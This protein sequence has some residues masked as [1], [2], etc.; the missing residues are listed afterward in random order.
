MFQ[1]FLYKVAIPEVAVALIR[2][3]RGGDYVAAM[4]TLQWSY[5]YGLRTFPDTDSSAGEEI[6]W[7]M[8]QIYK[9]VLKRNSNFDQLW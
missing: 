7:V 3:D 9:L 8:A 4:G 6:A 5:T 1:A 2:E